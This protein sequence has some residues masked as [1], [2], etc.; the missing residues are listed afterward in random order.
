[1]EMYSLLEYSQDYYIT[2]GRL[3]SYYRDKVNDNIN[4]N[5]SNGKSFTYKTKIVGKTS[6]R[7]APQPIVPILNV[8]VTILLKYLS[9]FSKFLSLLSANCK[10][11]LVLTWAKARVLNEHHNN[12]TGINFMITSTKL[13][14]PVVILSVNNNIK[15]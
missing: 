8:E 15:N 6:E 14:V 11:G 10:I 13:Y 2:S 12:I 7:P 9:N 5:A 1:M 3:W 4:N